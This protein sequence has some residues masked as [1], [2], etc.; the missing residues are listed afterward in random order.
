MSAVV[1]WRGVDSHHA[2]GIDVSAGSC[3][4]RARLASTRVTAI[5]VTKEEPSPEGE[6]LRGVHD[7]TTVYTLT[8]TNGH[9]ATTDTGVVT[10][11]IPAGM[12]FLGCGGV[13]NTTTGPEY[14]GAPS[15]AATPRVAGCVIPASVS[16]VTNPLGVP[17]GVYTQVTWNVGD[18]AP[19]Q[20]VT[21]RYAAGIPKRSNTVTWPGAPPPPGSLG[22]TANLDNNTGPSTRETGSETA[23]TNV[24]RVEGDYAGPVV[25]G[26]DTHVSATDADSV[27]AEDVRIRKSA[28]SGDFVQGGVKRYILTI[29]TS[30]YV[31]ASDIV[32]TDHIPNGLCPLDDIANYVAGTPPDC[33]PAPQFA[34]IGAT[35]TDVIQSPDG[36]FD[37][38]FSPIAIASDGTAEIS[39][40]ARMRAVYT[41]GGRGRILVQPL[42]GLPAARHP[43]A[44]GRRAAP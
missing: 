23:L 20:V 22:Q 34:P 16:T 41:G 15:L 7:H 38:T 1:V 13:D 26:T 3:V 4:A 27:T 24:V 19:D 12:E 44:R 5:E 40:S 31:D 8:V 39:Y 29:D 11:L 43:G 37:V 9:E 35:V 33:E 14:P 10:D 2:S 30:E 28:A 32:V 6:L 17:A 21:L 18:L 42:R 36:S 25:P